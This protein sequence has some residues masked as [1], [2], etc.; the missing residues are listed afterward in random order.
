MTLFFKGMKTSFFEE[1]I[2]KGYFFQEGSIYFL[3]ENFDLYIFPASSMNVCTNKIYGR[4]SLFMLVHLHFPKLPQSCCLICVALDTNKKWHH[5]FYCL[6]IFD[7]GDIWINLFC[8]CCPPTIK[9]SGLNSIFFK[10]WLK[11]VQS[12]WKL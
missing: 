9:K 12:V 3:S 7:I 2:T 4:I 8:S 11:I 1:S 10:D 5:F 6:N